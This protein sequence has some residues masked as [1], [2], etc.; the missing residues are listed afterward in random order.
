MATGVG[1][2][3]DDDGN[4]DYG[5]GTRHSPVVGGSSNV[6]CANDYEQIIYELIRWS[7]CPFEAVP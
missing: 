1:G 7:A 4:D 2:G 6:W 5:Y 3:D